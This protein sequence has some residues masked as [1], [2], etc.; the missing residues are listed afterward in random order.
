MLE[1]ETRPFPHV[2]GALAELGVP[3]RGEEDE[4]GRWKPRPVKFLCWNPC[5]CFCHYSLRVCVGEGRHRNRKCPRVGDREDDNKA[6]LFPV[7]PSPRHP[8]GPRAACCLYKAQSVEQEAGS[9]G[10]GSSSESRDFLRAPSR[11]ATSRVAE[12]LRA[13]RVLSPTPHCSTHPPTSSAPYS[14]R[15]RAAKNFHPP[16]PSLANFLPAFPELDDP[17]ICKTGKKG[18]REGG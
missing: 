13:E 15:H 18:R 3:G 11:P 4:S 9:S 5:L 1:S 8:E 2:G 16:P 6:G 14:H 10:G 12:Q 17:R 7:P